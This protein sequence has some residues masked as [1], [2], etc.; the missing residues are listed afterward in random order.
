MIKKLQINCNGKSVEL[1]A[2]DELLQELRLILTISPLNM[3]SVCK[4]KLNYWRAEQRGDT[5]HLTTGKDVT[6]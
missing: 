1:V 2:D 3:G 5:L 4:V 6:Q